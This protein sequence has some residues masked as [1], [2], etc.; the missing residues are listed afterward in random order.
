MPV[1]APITVASLL[2]DLTDRL[3]ALR[4][5]A[6]VAIDGADAADPVDF[7]RA[8]AERVRTRGR[9][10]AVIS[11]HDYVRPASLR[12]EYGRDELSY[13]TGWFD[14]AALDREVLHALRE[15]GRWLPALWD[16]RTDRSARAA[17]TSA[18]P[19]LIVIVAGP[20]LLGRGLDFD[21]SVELRLSEG[22]LRRGTGPDESFTVEAILRHRRD[23]A[24]EAD[25]LVAWDHRDRPA[26]RR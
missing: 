11:L 7:A 5:R 6:V 16:E 25:I 13:R 8:L 2:A 18:E 3:A 15:R 26:V 21:L 20:M 19:G 24:A 9:P 10:C 22:A 17:T 12:L 1:F 4:D 23:R 14:Y